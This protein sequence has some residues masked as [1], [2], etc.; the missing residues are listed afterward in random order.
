MFVTFKF[1]L[2]YFYNFQKTYLYLITS[3]KDNRFQKILIQKKMHEKI[4]EWN[5]IS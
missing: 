2:P 5:P 3:S 4:I 1:H